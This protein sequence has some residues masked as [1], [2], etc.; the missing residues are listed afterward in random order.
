MNS[1]LKS[2][3]FWMVLVAIAVLVWN[4]SPKFQSNPEAV[5]LQRVRRAGSTPARSRSV[6][7]T[8]NEITGTTKAQ[9]ELPHR[10]PRRSTK[11][12]PTA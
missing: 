9:R 11:A 8:G 7:I 2:L 12:S 10:S 6:E 5:E 1:T 4:F 3:V